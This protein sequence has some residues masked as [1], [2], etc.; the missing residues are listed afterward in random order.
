MC[1]TAQVQGVFSKN[2]I[3]LK[4]TYFSFSTELIKQF[5]KLDKL[6][7]EDKNTILKVINALIRDFNV[8]QAYVL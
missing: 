1:Y 5:K 2:V 4:D 7:E 6:P 3:N 8:R